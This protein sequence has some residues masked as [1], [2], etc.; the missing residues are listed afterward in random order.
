MII[1][2]GY[3]C[4]VK[5]EECI[6]CGVCVDACQFDALSINDH[7]MCDIE[8]CMGCG[9]CVENCAQGALFLERDLTKPAPLE[10]GQLL[11]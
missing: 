7:L 1:S 6:V 5:E 3:V 9:V 4:K 10:I 11:S 2:S 8:L